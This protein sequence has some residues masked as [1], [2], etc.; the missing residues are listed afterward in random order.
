MKI[1]LGS[2]AGPQ[3]GSVPECID[4]F[5]KE[6]QVRQ[7]QW[8]QRLTEDADKFAEIEAE[9]DQYY[10]LGAGQL[11][12][13]DA[14]GSDR[15]TGHERASGASS[16]PGDATRGEAQV[17]PVTC[18]A[19][20]WADVVHHDRILRTAGQGEAGGP[21]AASRNVSGTCG[22]GFWK[23]MQPCL[24]IHRGAYCRIESIDRPGA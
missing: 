1:R 2:A 16:H 3:L 15:A 12:R 8:A 10:R 11:D 17:T 13:R 9:I 18:S 7:M 20:L 6:T 14:S 23:G 21:G 4:H 5:A 19:A 24:A 22:I